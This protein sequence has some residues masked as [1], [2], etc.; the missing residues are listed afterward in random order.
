MASTLAAAQRDRDA[1]ATSAGCRLLF[2]V[3]SGDD[4]GN[5]PG[6]S[7]AAFA[8]CL[9]D[10]CDEA[11]SINLSSDPSDPSGG[12]DV[13]VA[14]E[15]ER[16]QAAALAA[17]ALAG[18]LRGWGGRDLDGDVAAR[19]FATFVADVAGNLREFA[20]GTPELDPPG[21]ARDA[22]NARNARNARDARDGGVFGRVRWRLGAAVPAG[23]RT[24]C[25]R[26]LSTGNAAVW[27]EC[28]AVV[29]NAGLA[30]ATFEATRRLS[31]VRRSGRALT[32]RDAEVADGVAAAAAAST[33]LL[34][35][36]I[37]PPCPLS[38]RGGIAFPGSART[39][40]K[41]KQQPPPR[42][43]PR[44]GRSPWRW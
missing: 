38:G 20:R 33:R 36:L 26:M 5:V 43:P 3:A 19:A 18:F 2:A 32:G 42:A 6:E 27:E 17:A 39:K 12:C 29:K 9:A 25:V 37:A 21:S 34:R 4:P 14:E 35:A 28:A 24:A 30:G 31:T 15:G 8:A 22:R 40:T 10:A 7:T 1:E 16:A 13:T 11:A 23:A 41:T 44:G